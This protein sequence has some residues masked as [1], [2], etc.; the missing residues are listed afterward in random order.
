MLS[1]NKEWQIKLDKSLLQFE[2][3]HSRQLALLIEE[4]SHTERL[5]HD[6]T[7]ALK[8]SKQSVSRFEAEIDDLKRQ[9]DDLSPIREKYERLQKQAMLMKVFLNKIFF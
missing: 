5:L 8:S 2:Q 1:S 9:L 3:K 7:D 4:K 6:S